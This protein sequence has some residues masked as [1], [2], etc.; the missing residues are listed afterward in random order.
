MIPTA[1]N[2]APVE[3]P[4]LI[5]WITPPWSPCVFIAKSPSMTKPRWLTEEYAT[6][7]FISGCTMATSAP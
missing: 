6:S 4:W 5:I 1:R 2:R 7:F 3:S